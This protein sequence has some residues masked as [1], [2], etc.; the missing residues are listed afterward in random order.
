MNSIVF[1]EKRAKVGHMVRQL[2]HWNRL[3]R[4]GFDVGNQSFVVVHGIYL[5]KNSTGK[6]ATSVTYIDARRNEV[7]Q[8]G[9]D[10]ST[11]VANKLLQSWD[12]SNLFVV[13]GSAFP[14]NL[15]NGSTETIGMPACWAADAIKDHYVRNRGSLSE[16]RHETAQVVASVATVLPPL[17]FASLCRTHVLQTQQSVG[18]Q[19]EPGHLP[20]QAN[21]VARRP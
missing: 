20:A 19:R 10:P 9:S 16:L 7:E 1:A 3:W 8:P 11:G 5:N 21:D 14:Q 18:K 4:I 2:R 15:A 13:G 17:S 12:V 6:R